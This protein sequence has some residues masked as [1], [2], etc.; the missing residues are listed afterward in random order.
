MNG[1]SYSLMTW[2]TSMVTP[3]DLDYTYRLIGC[4]TWMLTIF[5]SH[6]HGSVISNYDGQAANL[7]QTLILNIGPAIIQPPHNLLAW[8]YLLGT[9]LFK[10]LLNILV[11]G[12]N[13]GIVPYRHW[14]LRCV[15]NVM[16]EPFGYQRMPQ[17]QVV[18]R[19]KLRVDNSTIENILNI[20]LAV[21][22][23]IFI[24]TPQYVKLQWK[25]MH[26]H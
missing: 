25:N 22:V 12:W 14:N 2:C 1:L 15:P 13:T 3:T 6:L 11:V 17:R 4:V 20:H 19:W 8:F 26:P 23:F 16:F 10:Y 5:K 24:Y 21:C 7:Y 18:R 9:I